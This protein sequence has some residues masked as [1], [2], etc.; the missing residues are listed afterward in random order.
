MDPY[1]TMLKKWAEKPLHEHVWDKFICKRLGHKIHKG[2]CKRCGATGF[3]LITPHRF[4]MLE[5]STRE[6]VEHMADNIAAALKVPRE[7]LEPTN[8]VFAAAM[9]ELKDKE[10]E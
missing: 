8:T 10:K 2:V 5:S 4:P 1:R 6:D 7:Y 9:V 3:M